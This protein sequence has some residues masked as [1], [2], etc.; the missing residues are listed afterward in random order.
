M[1]A[2]LTDVKWYVIVILI[3]VSLMAGDAEHLF[4]YLWDFCMS[5]LEKC[6]FKSFAQFLIG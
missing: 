6:L 3:R 4:I 5:S 2:T 1:M